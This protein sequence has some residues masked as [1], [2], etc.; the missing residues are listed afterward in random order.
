M[1]ATVS[2]FT[3]AFLQQFAVQPTADQ[4]GAI[5]KLSAFCCSA[6]Y[7][8]VFILRGYAGTGKTTL[9]GALSRVLPSFKMKSELLAPT[10][11]AAKVISNYSQRHAQTIHRKIYQKLPSAD[12]GVYFSLATN[13]HK[14]TIF[15][16]DEASMIADTRSRSEFGDNN[17]LNDLL[18]YVFSGENCK[19]IF[20]GDTAQLPPVGSSFSPALSKDHLQKNFSLTILEHDLKTVVR[21]AEESG[22]LF[23]ATNLRVQL[24][25]DNK[26][27]P[28]FHPTAD[29]IRVDGYDLEDTL[30]NAYS[31]YGF[32]NVLVITRSNKRANGYNKQIRFKVKWQENEISA[33]DLLMV[34]KNNYFWTEANGAGKKTDFIANGESLEVQRLMKYRDIY[35]F[36]FVDAIVRLTDMEGEPSLEVTLMLDTLD[37]EAPALTQEQQ[38]TLFQNVMEDFGEQSSKSKLYAMLKQSPYYNALQ[39]KFSYAI[40]C[41]KAQGGQWDCIFIDQGYFTKEMLNEDYF[42]WLYTAVTRATKKVYLIGFTDEFF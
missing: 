39:I 13:N 18:E 5:D 29:V 4:S 16:V 14:N 31:K 8:E 21:Q 11:R 37:S 33:G 22:I 2:L 26:S 19:L 15:I 17:L 23:N 28:K 36:R 30:N 1:P 10:G 42:R 41:H 6:N 9:L 34:V 38:Q 27:F 3:N 12:G 35:G 40:T 7:R 25:S 24:L 32:E 20:T